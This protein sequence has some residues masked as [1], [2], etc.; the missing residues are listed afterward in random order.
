MFACLQARERFPFFGG[1]KFSPPPPT[2]IRK[3]SYKPATD[4]CSYESCKV[5]FSIVPGTTPPAG[6][7]VACGAGHRIPISCAVSSNLVCSGSP[8]PTRRARRWP[9]RLQPR[10]RIP[11]RK[12]SVSTALMTTRQRHKQPAREATRRGERAWAKIYGWAFGRK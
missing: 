3:A 6:C 12:P 8:A 2:L 1:V 5:K 10:R 11:G 9:G 7:A 4:T